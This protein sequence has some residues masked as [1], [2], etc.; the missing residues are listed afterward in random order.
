MAESYSARS[1]LNTPDG[2]DMVIGIFAMKYWKP[3]IFPNK[4]PPMHVVDKH[5]HTKTSNFQAGESTFSNIFTLAQ[6]VTRAEMPLT[7][8]T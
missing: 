4:S 1:S 8:P 6:D 7:V 3:S 5:I 2:E